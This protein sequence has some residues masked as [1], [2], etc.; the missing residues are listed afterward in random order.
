MFG[1]GCPSHHFLVVF[2]CGIIVVIEIKGGNIF[3][4]TIQ[5]FEKASSRSAYPSTKVVV[6]IYGIL[7]ELEKVLVKG[8]MTKFLPTIIKTSGFPSKIRSI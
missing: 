1:L 2:I 7:K 6:I 5:G 8:H 3:G 4:K